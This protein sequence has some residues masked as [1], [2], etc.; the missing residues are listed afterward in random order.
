M[1]CPATFGTVFSSFGVKPFHET[2]VTP[3]QK[4][5]TLLNF[6]RELSVLRG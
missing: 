2:S 1:I 3:L 4:G 6:L 5:L